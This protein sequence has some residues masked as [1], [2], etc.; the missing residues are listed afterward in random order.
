MAE[1]DQKHQLSAFH[2]R[3]LH[4]VISEILLYKQQLISNNINKQQLLCKVDSALTSNQQ[5]SLNTTKPVEGDMKE[6]G[7]VHMLNG[8]E[9]NNYMDEQTLMDSSLLHDQTLMDS[10][11][12]HE[13]TLMNSSLLHDQTLLN[14]S[15][16]PKPYS[17]YELITTGELVKHDKEINL[18]DLTDDEIN[19][20]IK[21]EQEKVIPLKFNRRR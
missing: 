8:K 19:I 15:S 12:L 17:D 16:V 9:A 7:V 6:L 4:R 13:Q 2:Q 11:L 20:Q 21:E 18:I 10:S 14:S 3:H 1:V 5:F